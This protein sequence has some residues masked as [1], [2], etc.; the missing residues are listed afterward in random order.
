M[1]RTTYWLAGIAVLGVMVGALCAM[2]EE[3]NTEAMVPYLGVGTSPV[4]ETLCRQ[5]KLPEGVGLVI[6]YV[7]PDGPSAQA[8]KQHDVLHKLGD[9]ILVSHEQLAVL[10]RSSEPGQD[11]N[12]VVLREGKENAVS[13]KL[14]S[15]PYTPLRAKAGL[16]LGLVPPSMDIFSSDR[17]WRFD[18]NSIRDMHEKIRK[19]LEEAG[20]GSNFV[21]DIMK[22]MKQPFDDGSVRPVDT[23]ISAHVHDSAYNITM[24]AATGDSGTYTVMEDGCTA[25]LA[26]NGADSQFRVTDKDGKVLYDGPVNTDQEIAKLP[27]TARKLYDKIAGTRKMFSKDTQI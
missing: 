24:R 22:M 23:N 19:Q 25:T 17:N 3:T 27:E 7:D 6:D 16:T 11:I 14:G 5:L 21:D 26:V 13:V 10:V 1:V 18:A 9:Q 8:L 4:D 12:L 15:K 20:K 2:A